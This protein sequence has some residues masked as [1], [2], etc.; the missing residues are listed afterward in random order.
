MVAKNLHLDWG[1]SQLLTKQLHIGAVGYV[2][3]Q[4]NPDSS[5]PPILGSNESQVF[6]IG[7]RVGH[8]LP[9]GGMQ[10]YLHLKA[11]REFNPA[12]RADEWNL[13]LTFA[14]SL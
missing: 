6:G 3:R 14:I 2:Y 9:I 5:A 12:R 13:W 1:A 10:G 11:C 7:P 4:I 8:L